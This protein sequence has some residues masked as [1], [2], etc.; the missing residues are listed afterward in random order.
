MSATDEF[1]VFDLGVAAFILASTGKQ[2][3]R[4]ERTEY[5][6]RSKFVFPAEARLTADRYFA[7]EPIN[8]R[9][10]IKCYRDLRSLGL[11]AKGQPANRRG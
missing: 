2:P 5:D 11:A 9:Q 3:L 4:V 10:L 7:G 8:G 1:V 6:Y